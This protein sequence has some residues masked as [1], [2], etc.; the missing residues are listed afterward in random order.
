SS[1]LTETP[2]IIYTQQKLI[3]PES[4]CHLS[5]PIC[6]YITLISS[7]GPQT[8]RSYA[9]AVAERQPRTRRTYAAA[10]TEGQLRAKVEVKPKTI[11]AIA[12]SKGQGRRQGP[13]TTEATTLATKPLTVTIQS[14][15]NTPSVDALVREAT[16]RAPATPV[17]TRTRTKVAKITATTTTTKDPKAPKAPKASSTITEGQTKVLD[18]NPGDTG[19][20]P[21]PSMSKATTRK[22][23]TVMRKKPVESADESD[24]SDPD[25]IKKPAKKKVQRYQGPNGSTI[26]RL[27]MHQKEQNQ[28]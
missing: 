22:R 10:L 8:R 18:N 17:A 24:N 20:A 13:A 21:P 5:R 15:T 12:Q 7:K 16:K 14:T 9:A 25:A 2:P 3:N 1:I 4:I 6:L 26:R 11:I 27:P 19:S 28:P 23:R